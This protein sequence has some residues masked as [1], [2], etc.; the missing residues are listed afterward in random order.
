M[1][2]PKPRN[3]N[4]ERYVGGLSKFKKIDNPLKLSA[5]E[6]ALGASPKAIETFERE[7]N[8]IFKYPDSDSSLL[9]DVISKKFKIDPSRII[10][11]AGS[12]QIFDFI[13]KVFLDKED[14]VVIPKPYW[15]TYPEA[16]KIAGG[17]P[18]YVE[19]NLES[20]YKITRSQ[21]DEVKTNRTKIL[22]WVSPSNPTGVVYTP[23]EAKDIYEWAFEN[24]I[25]I[26][27]D[28]LYKSGRPNI[29]PSSWQI[30]PIGCISPC[31]RSTSLS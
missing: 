15:T 6:S 12:D 16:V 10:C 3:I 25:W 4:I 14:E 17:K 18:V 22:V 30:V 20:D 26:L 19:S 5:N 27:S 7:K 23:E 21:L 8:K 24:D 29:C 9:R 2:L 31:L 11:G 1:I 28:E 13:C